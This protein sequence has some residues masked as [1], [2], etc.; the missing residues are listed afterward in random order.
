M[1]AIAVRTIASSILPATPT[2]TSASAYPFPPGLKGVE[3]AISMSR[4]EG[5]SG[6][7]ARQGGRLVKAFL[8]GFPQNIKYKRQDAD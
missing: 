6:K 4:R 7:K 5:N 3:P 2:P 1:R 8:Q